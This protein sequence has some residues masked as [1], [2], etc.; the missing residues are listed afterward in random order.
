MD[1]G[2]EGVIGNNQVGYIRIDSANQVK[3]IYVHPAFRRLGVGSKLYVAM[4]ERLATSGSRLYA[5]D[6]Q[7]ANAIAVWNYLVT[8]LPNRTGRTSDGRLFLSYL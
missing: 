3:F 4:A 8:Q 6:Y 5:S 2:L 7:H 1:D